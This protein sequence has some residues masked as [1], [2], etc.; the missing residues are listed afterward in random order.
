VAGIV[1]DDDRGLEVGGE[2]TP[3][4]LKAAAERVRNMGFFG[5]SEFD[6]EN[7]VMIRTESTQ[8]GLLVRIEV[9]ENPRVKSI[10]VTGTGPIPTGKI[11]RLIRTRVGLVFNTRDYYVDKQRIVEYYSKL[12]YSVLISFGESTKSGVVSFPVVVVLMDPFVIEGVGQRESQRLASQI[13]RAVGKW[14]NARKF[15]EVIL[16]LKLE[17]APEGP[18]EDI[19]LSKSP[20]LRLRRLRST[21]AAN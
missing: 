17:P 18:D 21:G 6:P 4:G 12:G 7:A 1:L 14:F 16:K 19:S 9:R 15:R 5:A 3:L 11:R 2:L 8:G 20:I 10:V 13:R